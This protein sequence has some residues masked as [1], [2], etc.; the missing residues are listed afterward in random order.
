M[1]K[2]MKKENQNGNKNKVFKNIE[3]WKLLNNNK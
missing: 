2:I 1:K 3:N